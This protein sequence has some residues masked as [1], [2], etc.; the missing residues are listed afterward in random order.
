MKEF[1]LLPI[2]GLLALFFACSKAEI[3]ESSRP[4][5]QHE[6]LLSSRTMS[7]SI[8]TDLEEDKLLINSLGFDTTFFMDCGDFYVFDTDKFIT[9][10]RLAEIRQDS[11]YTLPAPQ[12]ITDPN[13]YL[14]FNDVIDPAT[15]QIH[16]SYEVGGLN[17]EDSHI[18]EAAN[19]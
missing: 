19:A 4:C 12:F 14:N 6:N 2:L 11:T 15:Q 10:Q 16:I 3:E 9:K 8:S 18:I 17:V 13:L 5:I 1:K 7:V